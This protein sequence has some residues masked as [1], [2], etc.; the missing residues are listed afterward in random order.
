MPY[1]YPAVARMYIHVHLNVMLQGIQALAEV[2]VSAL[3]LAFI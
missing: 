1:T 3:A 2:I